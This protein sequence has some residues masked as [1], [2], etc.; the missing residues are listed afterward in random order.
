M[1]ESLAAPAREPA[2]TRLQPAQKG[3]DV[4]TPSSWQDPKGDTRV[5]GVLTRVDCDGDSARLEVTDAAGKTFALFVR[6]PGQVRL[7]NAGDVEHTFSC[8]AQS[9][10]VAIEF[11]NTSAEVTRIEF[12]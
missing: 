10:Q 3:P 7:V 2:S 12:R 9:L 8:G 4:I 6:H 1:A 5:E 11:L